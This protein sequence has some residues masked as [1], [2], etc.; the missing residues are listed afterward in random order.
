MAGQS[1]SG[2]ERERVPARFA[3]L[4]RAHQ[5]A[6][7]KFG[8]PLL[9]FAILLSPF[10]EL[11]LASGRV[12]GGVE[13]A[14]V[15]VGGANTEFLTR[16]LGARAAELSRG[17]IGVVVA[18]KR[19]QVAAERLGLRFDVADTVRRA[20]LAGREGS[21][22]ARALGFYRRHFR[23]ERVAFSAAFSDERL[24]QVLAELERTS[25]PDPP[26]AGGIELRG[27]EVVAKPGKSGRRIVTSGAREKLMHS[28]S[29]GTLAD[30]ELEVSTA[31]A[32]LPAS[33]AEAVAG[34]A[35]SLLRGP[36]TLTA[37]DPA[38][39]LE[40]QPSELA[41]CLRSELRDGALELVF[42]QERLRQLVETTRRAVEAEPVD[43]GFE[44]DARDQITIVPSKTGIRLDI[45]ALGGALL[46][47]A[48]SGDRRANLPLRHEP[49][50]ALATAEAETLGI[51]GLV[52]SFTTRHPC[53]EKRVDNIHRIAD[54][55]NGKLV[56][57]GETVSV[58][59]L[60][61]PRTL[62]NGFVPAPTIEEG[63]MVDSVGGGIS[64]F[65][66]TLFNALFHGGYE[67]IERQP[68]TYWFPRYPMGHDATLA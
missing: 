43:A 34:K 66:T 28:F 14:G 53:C 18:G 3:R 50:P 19:T 42:D 31:P 63:E 33:A 38:A 39:R 68:H 1:D 4:V 65:A 21:W 20:L 16:Q 22:V 48:A 52:T 46:G 8:V 13:V 40:L 60:V 61:G 10:V 59:A 27:T 36:I 58:N 47:A 2:P 55:L 62:K 41:A 64:Q 57:P 26:Y 29:S 51:K 6:I 45:P 17:Q 35:R 49:L 67:V 56:R 5:R 9:L 23:G 25:I 11:A 37:S 15:D 54:L 44:I 7:L 30:V 12:L 32:P 24:A